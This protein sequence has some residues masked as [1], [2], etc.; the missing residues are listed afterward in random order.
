MVVNSLHLP[1]NN[2]T[3]TKKNSKGSEVKVDYGA[4][5][6]AENAEEEEVKPVFKLAEE[7][8]EFIYDNTHYTFKDIKDWHRS[9]PVRYSCCSSAVT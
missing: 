9:A 8:I 4:E 5:D 3:K 6:A 1:G 2:N 7:D